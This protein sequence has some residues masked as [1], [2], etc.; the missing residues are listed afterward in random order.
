MF[1]KILGAVAGAK[2]AKHSRKVG[3]TG[4]A[5][6]GAAAVPLVRRMSIPAMLAIGAGGYAFKKWSDKRE[7][8]KAK[9]RSFETPPGAA[10][11]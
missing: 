3:G 7:A 9:R 6:L 5:F 11:A 1:G 4:G 2:A 10:K 8:Q